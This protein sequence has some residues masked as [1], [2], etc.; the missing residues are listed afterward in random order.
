MYLLG[1]SESLPCTLVAPESERYDINPI[2][3]S[4]PPNGIWENSVD[5]D[6]TLPIPHLIRVFTVCFKTKIL[7]RK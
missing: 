4:V 2:M 6:Q 1:K 5:P 3:H 7:C